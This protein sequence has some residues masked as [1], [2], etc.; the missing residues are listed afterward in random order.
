MPQE[1]FHVVSFDVAGTLIDVERGKLDDLR[2]TAPRSTLSD[3]GFLAACGCARNSADST[4]YH[5][6]PVRV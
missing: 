3:D 2:P 4:W 1:N 6:D 5:D